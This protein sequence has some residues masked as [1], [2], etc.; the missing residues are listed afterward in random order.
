M[1]LH[2][3]RLVHQALGAQLLQLQGV[4]APVLY[5]SPVPPPVGR[6]ARG[7]VPVLFPQFAERGAQP[8][9]G[10]ARDLPWQL[11]EDRADD[12]EHVVAYRLTV[13]QGSRPG[14]P[15][16][17]E[18]QLQATLSPGALRMQLQVRNTGEQPFAW[19]GGLHPYFHTRDLVQA[20]L[21]G[22]QGAPVADRYAPGRTREGAEP[23]RWNGAMFEC[24][25][26]TPAALVLSDGERDIELSMTGFDQ[27]MV[28]NPGADGAR[29]L[30]DLPDEAWRHFICIEPVRVDQPVELAPGESFS[31][32]LAVRDKPRSSGRAGLGQAA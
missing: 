32:S 6:P 28:W 26:D 29:A 21:R 3:P 8:K 9:H 22:L 7:G 19:T 14:W 24:L 4:A 17:A 31:G 2:T 18:L 15:H 10:W 11:L 20:R 25:Y 13:E 30:A 27:W 12:A 23:V 5:L 16:A 1:L